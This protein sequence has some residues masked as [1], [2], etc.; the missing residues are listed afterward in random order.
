MY[1]EISSDEFR[2]KYLENRDSMEIIDVRQE[3]EFSQIRI[4]WSK[5]ISMENLWSSLGDIDWNKE[6]IFVCRTWG[7]SAYVTQVLAQ[8][9][10]EGKNLAG[11]VMMLNINCTECMETGNLDA[12]YFE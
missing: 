11:G 1:K 8:N 5:L 10:Y 6:V 4:K 2:Q 7:R 3:S 9:W 12:N